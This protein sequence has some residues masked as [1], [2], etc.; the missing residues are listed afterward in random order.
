MLNRW[1]VASMAG[2]MMFGGM[3][4]GAQASVR[5]AV[6]TDPHFFDSALGAE[7]E[8][9]EAYLARDRKLIRESE[10]ITG[11]VVAELIK[12]HQSEPLDFILVPGDLTKDGER[13]SH[14]KFAGYLAQ[15]EAAGIPV[16]VVPGNHDV[17]NPH[18]MSFSGAIATPVATVSPVEFAN[19]YHQ[20]GY[21]EA[22]AMDTDSLSYMVEP[23]PGLVLLE[24]G[25]AHV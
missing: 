11:S 24:I 10:A 19:V 25:R 6:F 16:Y 1:L 3:V 5:F 20:F 12:A 8:A 13:L 4:A 7:G 18:A 22:K 17:N 15:I 21:G 14:E 23:V 9:F 2:M